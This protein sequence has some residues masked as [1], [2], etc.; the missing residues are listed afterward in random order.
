M[1]SRRLTA[2][3]IFITV[4]LVGVGIYGVVGHYSQV[5][6]GSTLGISGVI[7]C[8]TIL[9]LRERRAPVLEAPLDQDQLLVR[10]KSAITPKEWFDVLKGAH[11]EFYIA[12]HSLGKWCDEHSHD[13]F[14]EQLAWILRA[15]GKVTLVF[16]H[17]CSE[18]LPRLLATAK[19]DYSPN[20]HRSIELLREFIATLAPEH[21][22]GLKISL[23]KDPLY[24]PYML[25]GNEHM[26][27]TATFLASRDSDEMPCLT[28]DRESHTAVAIYDDFHALAN[29]V[30]PS[31]RLSPGVA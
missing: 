14:L 17:P 19:T 4:C 28:L 12:G 13:G 10:R 1:S 25:V 27:I 23:L 6:G 24:L 22:A 15:G 29:L 21:R 18:Q 16:L 2:P 26:L 5:V 20:V 30:D 7:A 8:S 11:S 9:T 31:D 3:L